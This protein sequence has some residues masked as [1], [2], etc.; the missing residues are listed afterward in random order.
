MIVT[1]GISGAT[2]CIY[3]IRLLEM[4]RQ[5]NV[6]TNLVISDW[7]KKTIAY[8]TNYTVEQVETLAGRVFDCDDLA[9]QISSG[10]HC[11]DAM[12]IAPCSMKTLSGIANG[13]GD[14]LLVRAADVTLKERRRLI[15]LARETPLNLSHIENMR[16]VTLMGGIIAPPVSAFYSRPKDLDDVIDQTTG[17]LLDLLGIDDNGVL[18]RWEG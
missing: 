11:A 10:S 9:A 3:G 18:R 7:G 12:V 8:E 17:R 14:N 16:T 4:L 1:I 13:Y 5:R 2:G 15:L 6:P